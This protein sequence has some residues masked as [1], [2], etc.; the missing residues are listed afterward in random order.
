VT[1]SFYKTEYI[2]LKEIIKKQIYLKGLF[3]QILILKRQF[4]NKLYTDSQSAIELAK[5]LIYHNR[6]KHIDIQYHFVRQTYINKLT[7]LVYTFTERQ[8][9]DELIKLIDN[10]K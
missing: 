7:N 2:T 4:K 8:L 1:L 3:G 5:N 10:N 6:T 9:T